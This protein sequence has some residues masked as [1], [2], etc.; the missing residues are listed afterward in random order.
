ND[1]G[2]YTLPASGNYELR[3]LQTR[4]D[5]RRNKTKKYRISIQ[6]K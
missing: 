3:I 4:N 1:A 5:A 2:K 6:I